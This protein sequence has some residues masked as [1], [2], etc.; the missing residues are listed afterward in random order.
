LF[1]R[2][3]DR[4]RSKPTALSIVRIYMDTPRQLFVHGIS[5]KLAKAPARA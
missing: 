4:E 3:P 2:C 5:E 1:A